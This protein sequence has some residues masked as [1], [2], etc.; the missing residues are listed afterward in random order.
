[1]GLRELVNLP[2]HPSMRPESLNE[3]EFSGPF[4]KLAISYNRLWNFVKGLEIKPSNTIRAKVTSIGT[5]LDFIGVAGAGTSIRQLRFK[6]EYAQY[7]SCVTWDGSSEGSTILVAKPSLLRNTARTIVQYGRSVSLTVGDN[8]YQRTASYDTQAWPEYIWPAYVEDDIIY[9][10]Q[11]SEPIG[12]LGQG[13][14]SISYIDL[15]VDGRKWHKELDVCYDN[16]DRK[17]LIDG[18]EI[19]G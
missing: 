8:A 4:R 13:E 18:S 6:T 12:D 5:T 9:A 2:V 11:V 16:A 7:L 10:V 19:Y 17:Q 15:N 14:E 3:A 1:M